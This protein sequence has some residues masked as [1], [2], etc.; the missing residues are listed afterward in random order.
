VD[1]DGSVTVEGVTAMET[2]VAVPLVIVAVPDTEPRVAVMT[3]VP[4]VSSAA[5]S[6]V[7]SIVTT[8][9]VPGCDAVQVTLPVRSC[10]EPSE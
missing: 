4:A 10:V 1:P 6:P 3:E 2:S 8:G 9:D 7:L 5:A